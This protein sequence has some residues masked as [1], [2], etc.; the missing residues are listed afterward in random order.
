MTDNIQKY[1][2]KLGSVAVDE[3]QDALD[4]ISTRMG[5]KHLMDAITYNDGISVEA[6]SEEYD[7]SWSM[8]YYWLDHF[9][10]MTIGETV[11][12]GN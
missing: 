8:I 7:I 6:A 12:A 1:M 9:E 10:H 5:A 11:R 4:S 2:E 3:L